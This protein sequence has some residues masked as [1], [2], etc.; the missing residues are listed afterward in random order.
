MP[1]IAF[2][3]TKINKEQQPYQKYFKDTSTMVGIH[4]LHVSVKH[5]K[6]KGMIVKSV[7]ITYKQL[8]SSCFE[9]FCIS[10]FKE[11][12]HENLKTKDVL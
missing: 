6:H 3:A 10:S 11:F 2:L 4:N 9:N 1:L 5:V 12:S 7:F 8:I